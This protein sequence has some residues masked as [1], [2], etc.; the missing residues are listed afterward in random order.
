MILKESDNDL[1]ERRILFIHSHE[2][3]KQNHK[4]DRKDNW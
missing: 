1:S 2:K 4:N 3:T